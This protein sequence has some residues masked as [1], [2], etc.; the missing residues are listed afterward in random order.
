MTS[1]A[2]DAREPLASAALLGS[3][4]LGEQ[5]YPQTMGELAASFSAPL[6][7]SP[8]SV[9]KSG[10]VHKSKASTSS[11]SSSSTVGERASHGRAASLGD[12]DSD[13]ARSNT[14]GDATQEQARRRRFLERNRIAASKCRQKKKLW[15][16]ELER[17]AE[18]VTMQNRSLHIAVAQLKEEVMILK[19]QL[20]AHR[21][22]NCSAIHQYLQAECAVPDGPAPSL[23]PPQPANPAV[24][25]AVAAAAG[26]SAAQPLLLQQQQPTHAPAAAVLMQPQPQPQHFRSPPMYASHVPHHHHASSVDLSSMMTTAPPVNIPTS[27][28]PHP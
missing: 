23:M 5:R 27:T 7:K 12:S 10:G 1:R 28:S 13:K 16:Q 4:L 18:D 11:T 15:V 21:N 19:N 9:V 8:V 2:E 25:A 22:C 14:D 17:R 6:T 20:L 3:A 26:T 24:V